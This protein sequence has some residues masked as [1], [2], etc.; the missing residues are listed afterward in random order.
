LLLLLLLLLFFK[1][2]NGLTFRCFAY[3]LLFRYYQ[4][5]SDS[6]TDSQICWNED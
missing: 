1:L 6:Y 4:I 3:P 5:T 2:Y